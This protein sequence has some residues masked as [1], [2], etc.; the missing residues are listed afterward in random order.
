MPDRDAKYWIERLHLEAHPE[1]G[2]FRQAYRSDVIIAREALPMRFGGD[3]SASTGILFLLEE[4]DFSAFH[5]LHS[6]EMWHFYEGAS[7][8]VHVIDSA[9]AHSK[10]YLGR[11][12]E[13]GQ[14]YQ[15][16]VT[17]G[18]WFAAEVADRKSYALVGCT[19]APGFDFE[20]FEL[21][22]QLELASAY[23]EHRELIERLTRG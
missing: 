21:A 2:Y 12:A 10:I 19:V 1:G 20:D 7:L 13:K 6:D 16:V 15:A 23:P 18:S 5:R 11:D 14:V 9:G 22:T 4:E 3:R 17:A 8:V